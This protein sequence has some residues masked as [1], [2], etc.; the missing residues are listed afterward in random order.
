[1]SSKPTSEIK[2]LKLKIKVLEEEKQVLITEN[3]NLRKKIQAY[4]RRYH[5]F[6][7]PS[8]DY[9]PLTYGLKIK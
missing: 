3:E 1:M 8:E 7:N 6:D 5:D 4:E 9:D 2:T